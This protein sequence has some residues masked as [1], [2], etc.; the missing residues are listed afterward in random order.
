MYSK[1]SPT[2]LNTR[3]NQL[4]SFPGYPDHNFFIWANPDLI[5]HRYEEGLKSWQIMYSS[6]EH[7]DEY[8]SQYGTNEYKDFSSLTISVDDLPSTILEPDLESYPL[9]EPDPASA[10][11]VLPSS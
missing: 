8:L 2:L 5:V 9:S 6:Y 7:T 11:R 10:L 3:L 1:Y 4:I